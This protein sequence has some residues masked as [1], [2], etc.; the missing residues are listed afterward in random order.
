MSGFPDLCGPRGWE[1]PKCGAVYAPTVT[2]CHRCAPAQIDLRKVYPGAGTSTGAITI[3]PM[4]EPPYTVSCSGGD[5]PNKFGDERW[6][7]S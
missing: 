5:N 6:K 4:P 1:C 3:K 7:Q 2:E